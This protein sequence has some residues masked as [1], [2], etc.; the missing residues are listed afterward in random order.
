MRSTISSGAAL[1]VL[2]LGCVL[3]LS[4]SVAWGQSRAE[5]GS[6]S[7]TRVSLHEVV[8][9]ALARNPTYADAMLE[10]R[11]AD[12]IVRET[13]AAWLPTLYSDSVTHLDG[14]RVESGSVV[15]A[16]NELAANVTLTV[17]LVMTRQWLTTAESRTSADAT[18]ATGADVRRLVAYATGQAYLAVEVIDAER[19]ARDAATQAEIAAD[20]SRQARLTLLTATNR[21]P[22]PT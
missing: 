18:K 11:R 3:P 5:V 2:G 21:F 9:R 20:A 17:P 4:A 7:A 6:A 13:K 8:A 12:A 22:E 10:V 19:S 1:G 15:L 16:Q 14:N